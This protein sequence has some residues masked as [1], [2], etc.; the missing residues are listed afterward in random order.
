MDVVVVACLFI[1]SLA[2]VTR[3]LDIRPVM[4]KIKLQF[5]LNLN[6]KSFWNRTGFKD[7]ANR[8]LEATILFHS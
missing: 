6:F 8:F 1:C 4:G 3:T 2:E 7:F 5:D